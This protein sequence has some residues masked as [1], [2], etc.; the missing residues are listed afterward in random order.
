MQ[1]VLI[2]VLAAF[3]KSESGTA[4][5]EAV[6]WLPVFIA[7][8]A[9]ATDASFIFFGQNKAYRIV[10]DANRSLS[11]GRLETEA[12]VEAF[13]TSALSGMSP[14]ATVSSTIA[15]GAV[16]SQITIPTS[17]LTS[18]NMI[19][20]LTGQNVYVRARHLVEY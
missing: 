7:F 14:N 9:L 16:T 6:L 5:I 18:I 11:V 2:R 8:I 10:Q 12:E 19:S 4:T 3:R 13:L 15:S 17:D 20:A 1:R